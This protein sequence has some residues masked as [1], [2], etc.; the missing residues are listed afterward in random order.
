MDDA[1]DLDSRTLDD[2]IAQTE[3]LATAYT[4]PG[5]WRPR[6]DGTLDLGGALIRL[7]GAMVDHLIKQLNRVPDKHHRAFAG[8]LGARRI[9]ARAAR[10]AIVFQLDSGDRTTVV[11]AGAQIAGTGSDGQPAVFET[12][13][14]I[15]L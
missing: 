9:P 12:E 1:P 15:A 2:V 14:E 10:A 4:A 13:L 11:P 8:L 3:A 7:F 6:S 5:P